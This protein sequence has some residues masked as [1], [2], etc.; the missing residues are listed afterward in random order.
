MI[1]DNGGWSKQP[2]FR[3]FRD[4]LCCFR[5]VISEVLLLGGISYEQDYVVTVTKLHVQ[6]GTRC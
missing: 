5:Y 4:V 1:P 3:T 2:R 6:N